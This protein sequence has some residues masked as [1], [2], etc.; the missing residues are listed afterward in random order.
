MS[1][2]KNFDELNVPADHVSR[3]PSD[4]YYVNKG[5]V[6]R[7][8]TSA[9]QCT[10]MRKCPE[11][12]SFLV[13]GDCFRRDEI[14]SSHYPVFHQCEGVRLFDASVSAAEVEDDLKRTLEGLFAHLFRL[15]TKDG[16][17]WS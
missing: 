1:T 12:D 14:D 16:A 13:A 15:T 8:H 4:T 2:K 5:M 3:S 6:L 10:I 7:T 9:H 17:S 11:V